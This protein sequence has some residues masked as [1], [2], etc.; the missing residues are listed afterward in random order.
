[1]FDPTSTEQRNKNDE[2]S[3]KNYGCSFLP[4]LF[5]TSTKGKVT[6]NCAPRGKALSGRLFI[7]VSIINP[8][9][10]GSLKPTEMRGPA[11]GHGRETAKLGLKLVLMAVLLSAAILCPCPTADTWY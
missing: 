6:G 1:M 7:W 11:R 5:H 3:K 2:S 10:Q 9:T 8:C 4:A